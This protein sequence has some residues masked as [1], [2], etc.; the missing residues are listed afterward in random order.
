M[1]TEKFKKL[2]SHGKFGKLTTTNLV[3]YAACSVSNFNTREG[4]VSE[5]EIA[6]M[7]VISA[8]GCSIIT[9]QGAYPDPKGEGKAYARQLSIAD[10]KYIPGLKRIADII[11]KNKAIAIQQILHGGRY[12]GLDLDYC[13]QASNTPQT[14]RHFRPPREMS[15]EE[16]KLCIKY[17]ADAAKRSM[18]AGYDGVEITGFMGYLISNFNSKFTNRRTD[19]Y[20]GSIENRARFMVEMLQGVRKVIGDAPIVIRLCGEELMD[21]Y[22]G[23]TPEE[24]I[25]FMKIAEKAGV[26]MISLVVGWHESRRGALG[27]DVPTE[28]WLP[29]AKKAKEALKIPIAFGPRFGSPV[30]AE[31]AM[32]EG[33]IDFWEVCRPFLADPELLQKVR[34]GKLN[35]I[36]PCVG[37]LLCL[38]RMFRNLPYIC[39][40]NPRL[41]HEVEPEYEVKPAVLK[42][43]VVV[44]GAGPA[45]MECAVTLA[46]RGHEVLLYE[47]RDR[48]GG[49]LNFAKN[50][51]GGGYVFNNLISYYESQIKNLGIKVFLNTELD[52]KLVNGLK[53]DVV[54]LATG[55]RIHS[56]IAEGL[57]ETAYDVLENEAKVG[58]EV[59]I[60][61]A[62]K[63]GLVTAEYLA[64]KGKKVAIIESGSKIAE[65]VIP[66][67]KWR[68]ISWVSEYNIEVHS[69]SKIKDINKKGVL[70]EDK[71][72]KERLITGTVVT[73]IKRESNQ[74][75]FS[76][77]EFSCDEIYIIGDAIS[78]R[79]IH[80]AVHEGFKLG[81]R[82]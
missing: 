67:F 41:G 6:R 73:S 11:H 69:N 56:N 7:E 17:H 25:E 63:I 9:N 60:I 8:T 61:G 75:L 59:V 38:S 5:R 21:E 18:E 53:P 27:R 32:Q 26:S 64:S 39:C 55:A 35:E 22:G 13:V 70:I 34:N 30:L 81:V 80:N 76:E 36:K 78:P 74:K 33:V 49:L 47:K 16:I 66:T 23:N 42:K 65:D 82:I 57:V 43:K 58:K 2:L 79:G 19:E 14:L 71:E 3:K 40:M 10:D 72:G 20:G 24:C 77:L 15:K 62:G 52:L 4:F 28:N 54:V 37:D 29:L 1:A 48:I 12:G 46:K 68:H 44:A 50:E 31:K 45:G 51:V